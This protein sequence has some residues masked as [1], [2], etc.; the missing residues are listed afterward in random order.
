MES[1][2]LREYEVPDYPQKEEV[3]A[4]PAL[5]RKSVEKRWQKLYDLGVSGM[6]VASLSLSGCEENYKTQNN[7]VVTSGTETVKDSNKSITKT[8]AKKQL[9][10]LVAPVFN[11]GE[12]RG[13]IG[14]VAVYPPAFLSEEEALVV[15]KEE[16][17][18]KGINLNKEKV[19]F[20]DAN[21][22]PLGYGVLEMFGMGKKKPF[23]LEIDSQDSNKQI[24]IEFISMSDCEQLGGTKEDWFNFQKYDTRK[25]A[26]QFRKQIQ[27]NKKNG[28]YGVFYDPAPKNPLN[29]TH[30]REVTIEERQLA[31]EQN[32]ELA[33]EQLRKQ[34]Q[35]FA[36]WLKEHEVI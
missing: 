35:D 11:H 18:K 13:S 17:I 6:L 14:C 2:A 9:K 8:E 21:V 36:N 15:I 27:S 24:N 32:E 3:Q 1:K 4:Q 28:V 10:I 26:V 29:S 22:K 12:G 30:D 20:G 25:A 7:S 23:P 16:L 34:V 31:K 19:V 33:R 5:L